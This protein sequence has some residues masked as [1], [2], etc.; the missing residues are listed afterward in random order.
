M[1]RLAGG[2][3]NGDLC[4]VSSDKNFIA[5]LAATDASVEGLDVPGF[6]TLIDA[7]LARGQLRFNGAGPQRFPEFTSHCLAEV[8]TCNLHGQVCALAERIQYRH[9][10]NPSCEE[11]RRLALLWIVCSHCTMDV[12]KHFAAEV[13]MSLVRAE[14]RLQT[15]EPR[16]T[17][18]MQQRL[19]VTVPDLSYQNPLKAVE[20]SLQPLLADVSLG[21]VL[22]PVALVVLGARR[23]FR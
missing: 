10:Q 15:K 9:I 12:P 7:R 17:R 6:E 3:S 2:D 23:V 18:S 19:R 20:P 1:T 16:S 14:A 21:K 5:L 4:C 22:C 8:V 11:T 13:L